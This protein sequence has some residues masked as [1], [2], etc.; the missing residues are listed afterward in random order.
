MRRLHRAGRRQAGLLLQLPRRLGRRPNSVDGRG[1]NQERQARSAAGSIHRAR[2]PAVR[3]LHVGSTDVG[4]GAPLAHAAAH[5]GR[6]A[7]RA[8]G[9]SLSLLQLQ[10]HRR[11][12][13]GRRRRRRHDAHAGRC[14]VS[15]QINAGNRTGVNTMK[16]IGHATPRIDAAERVSGRATY[17]RDVYLDGMLYAQ[18]LRSPHPHA[19][20]KANDLSKA[21]ALHGV[22]AIVTNENC[23]YVW[24]AGSIAGGVQYNDDVKKITT[25]RRYAFNNPVRY[26]GEPIAA[27]AAVDRHVAEEAVRLITVEYEVLPFVL[28]QEAALK[29]DAV[30]IWP[31][32]NISPDARNQFQPTV[33]KHGNVEEGFKNADRVFEAR[34]STV[35]CH[36]AQMEPR[37]CVAHWE[38]DKL[39]VYT[40]TGGIANC[41]HDIARDLGM[42]DEKVRVICQYMGGNFGNK[43]QNQDA[44]LIAALLAKEAGAPV[45]LELSRREDFVGMHGRWPTT[46]YFKVGVKNDGTL[47]AIQLRGY[48]GMGPYRKNSGAIAGV[49]IY[50]CPNVDATVSPVYTNKT[51]SGNFRGPEFPQGYFG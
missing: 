27:I 12:G 1:P 2:R 15:Q 10:P 16:V 50:Q 49:D 37:S 22:K 39:T 17:T 31:E 35:M 9:Q 30:K 8:C 24:G 51:V 7:R 45:K 6:C 43:N 5:A 44:D 14:L 11:S 18:V 36:N 20:I 46:Q 28:D 40:P 23:H 47:T 29:D 41:H 4:Q 25:Q 19:R 38:G 21:R 32:G 48:S 13:S 26:V 3:L 42:P 33:Q 34:Y